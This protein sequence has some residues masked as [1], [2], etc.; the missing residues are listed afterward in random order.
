M[1]VGGV[2]LVVSARLDIRFMDTSIKY[3]RRSI[4][5]DIYIKIPIESK[6]P[7]ARSTKIS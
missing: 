5:N 6:L 1:F 2:T 4:D 3:L 7:K